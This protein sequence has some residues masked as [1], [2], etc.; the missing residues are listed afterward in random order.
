ME[1]LP[2]QWGWIFLGLGLLVFAGLGVMIRRENRRYERMDQAR[3]EQLARVREEREAK[4]LERE[5]H[6]RERHEIILRTRRLR[7]DL[8]DKCGRLIDR[9]SDEGRITEE[10]IALLQE[11]IY[12]ENGVIGMDVCHHENL[13]YG[14]SEEGDKAIDEISDE[15]AAAAD[16]AEEQES[17]KV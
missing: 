4:R 14:L 13:Y 9:M 15:E 2:E 7:W 6:L 10:E 11:A 8:E 3:R 12:I 1:G 16:L 17:E 5:Q